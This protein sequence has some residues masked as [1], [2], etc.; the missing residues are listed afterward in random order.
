MK[1]AYKNLIS[2]IS[3]NKNLRDTDIEI[4]VTSIKLNP[5]QVKTLNDLINRKNELES[6]FV[7]NDSM[8]DPAIRAKMYFTESGD[9]EDSSIYVEIGSRNEGYNLW[10]EDDL[11]DVSFDP[12]IEVIEK[13]AA[14]GTDP[15]AVLIKDGLKRIMGSPE[16]LYHVQDFFKPFIESHSEEIL[17]YLN[18]MNDLLREFEKFFMEIKLPCW[19]D[20]YVEDENGNYVEPWVDP[21]YSAEGCHIWCNFKYKLLMKALDLLAKGEEVFFEKPVM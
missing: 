17:D 11:D 15:L 13:V 1:T 2:W 18:G 20:W 19:T 5:D 16:N 8:R 9:R 7:I 10:D 6:G 3:D 4:G 12:E 21:D 14:Q